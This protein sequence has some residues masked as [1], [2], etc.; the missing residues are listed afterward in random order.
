MDNVCLAAQ[1][2]RRAPRPA[3]AFGVLGVPAPL[4]HCVRRR[5]PFGFCR[6]AFAVWRLALGVIMMARRDHDGTA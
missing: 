2:S 4:T 1:P 3:C 5:L 6:L